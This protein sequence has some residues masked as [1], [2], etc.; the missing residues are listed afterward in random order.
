MQVSPPRVNMDAPL[1]LLCTNLDYDE[2]KGRIAIGRI[3]S[4]RINKA[5]TVVVCHPGAPFGGAAGDTG[6]GT[7]LG[8]LAFCSLIQVLWPAHSV[9]TPEQLQYSAD[10]NKPQVNHVI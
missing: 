5:E 3:T 9:C 2:H 4:G 7:I 6:K 8:S 10:T 1:Q